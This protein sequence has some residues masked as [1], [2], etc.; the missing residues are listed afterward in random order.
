MLGSG[1]CLPT[2]SQ[3]L[4]RRCRHAIALASL[5]LMAAARPTVGAE[6]V[7]I[8]YGFF[9]RTIAVED[10]TAFAQGQG[11]S[12]Q[13][14]NYAEVLQLSEE[15]LTGFQDILTE[16]VDLSE[17]AIAQFLYTTQGESLLANIGEILQTPARQSGF[18]AIRS[19][20]IL[21]AADDENGLTLLNFLRKFPTP[22]IRVDIAGG[23]GIASTI[24]ETVSQAEQAIDLVDRIAQIELQ[25]TDDPLIAARLLLNSA[26]PYAITS[27]PLNLLQRD[28]EG[29]LY[30]PRAVGIPLPGT[31]PVIVISHGLGDGRA[32]Y[33]YLADYL[34]RRG[35]AVATLDHP[36]SNSRQ[37]EALLGGFSADLIDDQE[38]INRPRDVSALLDAVEAFAIADATFQSRLNIQNVGVIGQSFGGY[39][40]LALAGATF[41]IEG[42]TA[43]CGGPQ[44][45]YLNPSLLLQCQ[46][47]DIP[48]E[49]LS[50]ADERIRSIF[51]VNP[52]GSKIFGES[53]YGQ[54][55]M[56]VMIMA[57]AADT[58]A[59][60]L[61]E[62]IEPFTWLQTPDRYLTLVNEANHFSVIEPPETDQSIPVP[63]DLLGTSPEI[64]QEY[65]QKLSLAFFQRHL[66]GNLEYEM[67]LTSRFTEVEM[68]QWP[69]RPL[70]LIRNLSPENLTQLDIA[71]QTE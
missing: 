41:D 51:V 11:L 58:V 16:R 5:S 64:A 19:S 63:I 56:P 38:F 55:D 61:P 12:D 53:G 9:E 48:V 26:P 44:A 49:M 66:L 39:T 20:L 33:D 31:V 8:T 18:L 43:A 40:A 13:L 30:L 57:G 70:S 25:R 46:V 36:G 17:I 71:P 28:V 15:D 47:I 50:L 67:V 37:I 54:L 23:L 68:A 69:L 21:S 22:G 52:I 24:T 62:Q 2:L 65:L 3:Y 10:L 45:L 1:F 14:E 32:S 42:L 59:P 34:A 4:S 6:E 29:T 27:R 7:I 35:F 60:A